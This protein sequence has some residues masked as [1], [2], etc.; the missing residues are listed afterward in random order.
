MK[1]F[2]LGLPVLFDLDR[3]A[4]SLRRIIRISLKN[5]LLHLFILPDKN[6]VY[7]PVSLGVENEKNRELL[8][9]PSCE[10]KGYQQSLTFNSVIVVLVDTAQQGTNG[11][12]NSV[13]SERH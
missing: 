7:I 1:R 13:T 10:K 2:R 4:E 3:L 6:G 11:L 12:R 5:S 8:C 9:D